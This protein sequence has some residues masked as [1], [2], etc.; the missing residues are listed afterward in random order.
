METAAEELGHIE[1]RATAVAKNTKIP[2]NA[3]HK[4][5]RSTGRASSHTDANPAAANPIS[6]RQLQNCS[7][8]LSDRTVCHPLESQG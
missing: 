2:R 1:M 6:K 4:V 3:G 5:P 7:T 8:K